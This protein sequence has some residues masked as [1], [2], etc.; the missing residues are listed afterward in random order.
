MSDREIVFDYHI[1]IHTLT[2]LIGKKYIYND[3]F[4]INSSTRSLGLTFLVSTCY[5][6]EKKELP[7]FFNLYYIP[8]SIT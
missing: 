4:H 5:H 7:A 8:S 6:E 2:N 1:E 3:G